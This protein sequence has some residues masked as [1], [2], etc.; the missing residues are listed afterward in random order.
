MPIPKAG[1]KGGPA[2]VWLDEQ[3]AGDRKNARVIDKLR[4]SLPVELDERRRDQLVKRFVDELTN[5]EVPWLAAIHDKGKDAANPHV[6]LVVR[7]RHIEHGKRALG[8][9]EKGSTERV[10][11]LGT[12]G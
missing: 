7:D 9:S 5:G 10:R 12:L 4:L 3:E 11:E 2:R 1:T 8:M 6:H